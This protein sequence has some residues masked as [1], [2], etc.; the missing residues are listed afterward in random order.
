MLVRHDLEVV[1]L[2]F[3][4]IEP[5][6]YPITSILKMENQS[7]IFTLRPVLVESASLRKCAGK[8]RRGQLEHKCRHVAK[9]AWS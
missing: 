8:L 6:N 1:V 2:I 9:E 4:S 5:R 3:K 7:D